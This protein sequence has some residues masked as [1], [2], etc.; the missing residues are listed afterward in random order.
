[1]PTPPGRSDAHHR[2]IRGLCFGA[3]V[4]VIRSAS[5]VSSDEV[6]QVLVRMPKTILFGSRRGSRLAPD[7]VVAHHPPV[8]LHR[9]SEACWK[10]QQLLI[11]SEAAGRRNA[12]L[13][14]RA[15]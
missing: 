4:V 9:D 2:F 3:L 7:E 6:E 12:T 5:R 11:G 14:N 1:M 8:V 10:Q 15:P 13:S